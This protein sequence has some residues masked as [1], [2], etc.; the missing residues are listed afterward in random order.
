MFYYF[1]AIL[2][3]FTCLIY[4]TFSLRRI[5]KFHW[6]MLHSGHELT[7]ARQVN[8]L[9][10]ILADA[11]DQ[12]DKAGAI[13]EIGIWKGDTLSQM[14]RK[15]PNRRAIGIDV[16]EDNFPTP[17]H[18]RDVGLHFFLCNL[19]RNTNSFAQVKE[20]LKN[21]TNICLIKKD[22]QELAEWTY[23]P[24]FLLRCDVDTYSGTLACLQKLEKFVV[25]GGYIII[26]DMKNQWLSVSAAVYNFY[27]HNIPSF[28]HVDANAISWQK[29]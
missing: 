8:Y 24:I 2:L 15:S 10:T 28:H 7:S 16:F 13:V 4:I 29:D 26:D 5:W 6:N 11:D 22:I 21:I 14:A 9:K 20:N 19:Y 25:K 17:V 3:F 27:H 18:W 23:G 1:A 12:G